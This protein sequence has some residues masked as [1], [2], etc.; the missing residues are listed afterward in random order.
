VEYV[1]KLKTAQNREIL[2][3]QH[4]ILMVKLNN[5]ENIKLTIEERNSDQH[6]KNLKDI[7]GA[8]NSIV[9]ELQTIRIERT[10]IDTI[11]KEDRLP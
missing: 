1:V 4:L 10:N 3:I 2:T 8:I 9:D 7:E 5:M 6:Q 11:T